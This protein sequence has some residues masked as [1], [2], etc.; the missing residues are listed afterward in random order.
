MTADERAAVAGRCDGVPFYIEQVVAGLSRDRG[1][2]GAVRAVVR[3]AARQRERGAGGGGGRGHRPPRRSRS[4]V[5]GGRPERRRGRRRHRRARGCAGAGAVGNQRLA[6][7]PRIAAR[8]RRRVGARR[9]CAGGCT[10][11]WP[12]RWSTAGGDPDWRLVA[13]HYERAER[14]DEAAAA[15]QQAS[16]DA[17]RRGALAEAR[18]YLTHALAQLDRA[19]PA[20]T[21]TAA[22]SAARL[23]R[24]FLAVGRRG[25][26]KPRCC[27]R[28][29]AVPA[30]GRDRP[31]RR[32][33]VR[34]VDRPGQ[35]LRRPCRLAAGGPGARVA[36]R[37]PGRG[38]AVV[39]SG[40]RD[41]V[42]GGGVAARRI[43]RRRAPTS[44][45]P[46]RA[47]PRQ[48]STTLTRCGSYPTSRS[49]RRTSTWP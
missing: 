8:G 6:V 44:S 11:K 41:L 15:Y 23:E 10:P 9:A 1:A 31:A 3:P 7:S 25:L 32:R 2:R 35:L 47:R 19:H 17:R 49:R 37:G 45:R 13:A 4:A 34:D 48:T 21:V 26:S 28:F 27:R 22:R 43:R 24:G 12:T 33:A 18:T 14:F 29:R 46:R 5:R 36:A 39:P 16:T 30:A 20:R 40:D 38:A 42:R